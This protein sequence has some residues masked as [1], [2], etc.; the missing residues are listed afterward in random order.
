MIYSLQQNGISGKLLNILIDFLSNRKQRVVFNGQSSNWID[1]TAG[2]PQGSILGDLIFLISINDLPEG[3]ITNIKLFAA[4][5]ICSLFI[6]VSLEHI[7]LTTCRW[8]FY[9]VINSASNCFEIYTIQKT[10]AP[11]K[12]H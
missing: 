1:N 6:K 9:R 12:K 2:V 4:D 8:Q 5:T 11:R 3:L 10:K 7:S